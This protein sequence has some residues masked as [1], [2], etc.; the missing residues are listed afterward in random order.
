MVAFYQ[1][2][3]GKSTGKYYKQSDRNC[4]KYGKTPHDGNREACMKSAC[5]QWTQYRLGICIVP[6]A[7]ALVKV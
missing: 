2:G 1:S 4:L 3:D 6:P 5:P 7:A